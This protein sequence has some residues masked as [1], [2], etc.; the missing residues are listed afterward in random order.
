MNKE[1]HG[2]WSDTDDWWKDE[3]K[4]FTSLCVQGCKGQKKAVRLAQV[5]YIYIYILN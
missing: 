5:K 1:W 2:W 4:E 3:K